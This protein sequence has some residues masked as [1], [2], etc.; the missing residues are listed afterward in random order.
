[1]KTKIYDALERPLG[2]SP[3]KKNAILKLVLV[4][5]QCIRT[6]YK[7]L[8]MP[9]TEIT[10]CLVIGLK[11]ITGTNVILCIFTASLKLL[12]FKALL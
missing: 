9:E 11:S 3:L 4:T 8:T 2:F 10:A 6:L 7:I 5:L 1:M 12:F